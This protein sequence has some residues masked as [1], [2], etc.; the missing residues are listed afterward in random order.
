MPKAWQLNLNLVTKYS[1]MRRRIRN[2]TFFQ[3]PSDFFH[4]TQEN[5]TG[6]EL[7]YS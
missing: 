4:I 6:L 3:D 2:F 7:K 1:T 5:A